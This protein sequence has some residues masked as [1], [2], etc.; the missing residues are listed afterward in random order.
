MTQ[1]QMIEINNLSKSYGKHKVLDDLSLQ[2]KPG[3]IV[4]LLGPNGS[5][6]TT[7]IK[8]INDLLIPQSGSIL[9]DGKQPGK[10]TKSK[11]AFLPEKTF[12]DPAW[13]AKDALKIYQDFYADFNQEQA[14]KF[15]KEFGLKE[16]MPIRSMS[17]GMLEKLTL[18]LVLSREADI[19]I[20]D[21]PLG[22][23]DPAA[24]DQI[25][26]TILSRFSED[27]ILILST[28]L[29]YDIERILDRAIFIKHGK[30][31]MDIDV[32]EYR[33]SHNKSLD[34]TFREV[35]AC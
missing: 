33:S 28:H 14:L 29:I 3:T 27:K 21:E 23:I 16:D 30:V 31:L 1:I 7:L 13:K 25:L 8:L 11:I 5:G 2:I 17:K 12:L 26:D 35:Y 9:I 6:K 24:R 15:M 34:Q 22:G 10:I 19:F 18:L 20:L 32:E 4:G